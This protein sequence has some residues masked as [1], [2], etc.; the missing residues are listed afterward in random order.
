MKHFL[1]SAASENVV[2]K[3]SRPG[4]INTLLL[5]L[6]SHPG[7]IDYVRIFST[8][9]TIY[10]GWPQYSYSKKNVGRGVVCAL[11][12]PQHGAA[13]PQEATEATDATDAT[14][15]PG[16]RS[17]W[18]AVLL[19]VLQAEGQA[20]T[21]LREGGTRAA[22]VGAVH[23]CPVVRR[24]TQTP[25]RDPGRRPA[26]PEPGLRTMSRTQAALRC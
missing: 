8:S 22:R 21:A 25:H 12:N 14:N 2:T 1:R 17:G 4:V 9:S 5:R 19:A 16:K 20:R 23:A 18:E 11:H 3:S 15:Q 10:E 7:N 26:L 24:A 6:R 13:T